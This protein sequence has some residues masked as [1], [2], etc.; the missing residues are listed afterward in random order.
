M[1]VIVT[2][3]YP[4]MASS[5]TTFSDRLACEVAAD[6]HALDLVR[7]LEDLHDL[8]LAHVALDREVRRVAVAAEHLHGIDGDPHRRV[9]GEELRHRRLC[10]VG[11]AGVAATRG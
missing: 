3:A 8:H 7:A 1:P 10:R 6:H 4:T 2:V 11:L 9:R 5:L